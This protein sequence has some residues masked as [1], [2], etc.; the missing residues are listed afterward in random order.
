[1]ELR[2]EDFE[3]LARERLPKEVFDFVSG[4]AGDEWTLRENTQVA[5]AYLLHKP[6]VSSLV[7]GARNEAQLA[8][9]L[10]AAEL[11]LD[12]EEMRR[13]DDVSAPPLPYPYWWQAK[14]D[15]RLGEA[16]LALLGRYRD[17]PVDEGGLHRPLPGFDV[18]PEA[19]T[20]GRKDGNDE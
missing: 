3:P 12:E 6:G 2:V 17:V 5:L 7:I 16:D 10:P 11:A 15:E 18:I 19:T 20:D 13:L 14:Y 8:E 1:M 9:D 4:G